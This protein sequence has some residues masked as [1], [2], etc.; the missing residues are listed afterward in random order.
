MLSFSADG[1]GFSCWHDVPTT[2]TRA[3]IDSDFLKHVLFRNLLHNTLRQQVFNKAEMLKLSIHG[4][5]K[6]KFSHTGYRALGPEL[7]PV[8]RQSART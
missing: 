5:V 2:T 6:V 3:D 7:I 8:Y 4:K 1:T